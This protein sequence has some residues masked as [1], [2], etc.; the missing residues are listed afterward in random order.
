MEAHPARRFWCAAALLAWFAAAPVLANAAGYKTQNFVVSAPT[1]QLAK[2]IGDQA[3]HCRK[4]LALEWLGKELPAW[5]QPCPIQ[6]QVAPNLGAGGATSFVFDRG[7]VF[8]WRMTIQGSRER[9]LD[10]VVPHEVTHTIFATH[11]R[12]P[13][14][15]WADEGACTTVEHH[16][17]IAKQDRML[18]EFL[19]TRRGIPFSNMFAMEEYPQDVLPLYAQGYSLTKFLL[20][21][22][23]KSAYIA[24]LEDGLGTGDWLAAV[25]RAYGYSDLLTLQSTWLNWIQDGQPPVAAIASVSSGGDQAASGSGAVTLAA[26]SAGGGWQRPRRL[27]GV[28]V[29]ASEESQPRFDGPSVYDAARR[30]GSVL[31]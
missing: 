6:A 2:E 11:F 14:P 10:S 3:E 24:F 27:S 15:R 28:Q 12:Q 21:Q 23:G 13:L 19:Q 1:P 29:A 16:S 30:T 17:E 20:D 31:R 18:I 4:Q 26:A 7:Q 22:G 9:I 5:S 8:G 25:E